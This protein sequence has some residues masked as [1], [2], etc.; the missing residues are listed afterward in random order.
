M[1]VMEATKLVNTRL[2]NQNI[3]SKIL[4]KVSKCGGYC[5]ILKWFRNLTFGCSINGNFYGCDRALS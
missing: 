2:Q 4:G 1:A 3:P 5:L